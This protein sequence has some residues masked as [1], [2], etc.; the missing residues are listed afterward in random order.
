MPAHSV[1]STLINELV[2]V[3][4]E[5][6]LF[7]DDY[8]LISLP[9]IHDAMSYFIVNAPSNVHVVVCT[10]TDP[11]LPLANLRA[12]N[13]LLEIDASALRFNF[14]ETRSFVEHECP[15]GCAPPAS[16]RCSRARKA[17][18]RRCAFLPRCY[19]ATNANRIGT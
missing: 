11:P 10:R 4:D 1:V 3:D 14:D 18:L 19:R 5:V 8:H 17:G 6:Y 2:E 16:S 15:A 9:A 13:D 12:R 7:L